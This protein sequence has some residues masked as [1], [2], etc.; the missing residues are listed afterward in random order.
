MDGLVDGWLVGC[1]VGGE[2][3]EGGGIV[4]WS[5]I[6]GFFACLWLLGSGAREIMER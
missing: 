2:K 6:A 1:L 5:Y 3:E 4:G